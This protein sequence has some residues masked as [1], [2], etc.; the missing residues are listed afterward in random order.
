MHGGWKAIQTDAS[1]NH[2]NSGGPGFNERGEV[3]GISTAGA[4]GEDVSG[5]Y[6]LVPISVVDQF[7]QELNIKPRDSGLSAQYRDA[8]ALY[9]AGDT[10]GQARAEFARSRRS[11]PVFHLWRS[12]LTGSTMMQ[13][14]QAF[15]FAVLSDPIVGCSGAGPAGRGRICADPAKA[16]TGARSS[17]LGRG[18]WGDDGQTAVVATCSG[19]SSDPRRSKLRK[20][21]V[22]F[23]TARRP[24]IHH[25][26]AGIADRPRFV[27]VPG[28]AVGGRRF[29][30][31]CLGPAFGWQRDV[32]RPWL[33]QRSV[34]QLHGLAEGQQSATKERRPYPDRQVGRNLYLL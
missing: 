22:C 9:D 12:T 28:G 34:R 31:A 11:G 17:G 24:T 15:I 13:Q 33:Y 2:G 1:I 8:L 27:Q 14:V 10:Q 21:T 4:S 16:A 3:I 23:R 5:L 7:I 29:Q 19:R 18:S 25:T 6:Y 32:D 20:F 26:Q 30:R